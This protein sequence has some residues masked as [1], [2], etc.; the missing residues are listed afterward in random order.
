[1]QNNVPNYHVT[2]I[3]ESKLNWDLNT[4]YA[5]EKE[6]YDNT[7]HDVNP[8]NGFHFHRPDPFFKTAETLFIMQGHFYHVI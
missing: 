4:A 2:P 5:L 3:D 6:K 8:N 7:E 1:M